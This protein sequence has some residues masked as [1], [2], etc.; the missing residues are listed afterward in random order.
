M[1]TLDLWKRIGELPGGKKDPFTDPYGPTSNC[2]SSNDIARM[3]HLGATLRDREHLKAC[4]ECRD[5]ILRFA[6]ATKQ[7]VPAKPKAGLHKPYRVVCAPK[8]LV[9]SPAVCTVNNLGIVQAI[10]MEIL[11]NVSSN[12]QGL[13]LTLRGPV[14]G[15]ARPSW[16]GKCF[17]IKNVRASSEVVKVLQDHNRFMQ[18]V[19]LQFG[20]TSDAPQ[21][22]A[23][24]SLEFSKEA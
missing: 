5:R 15:S 6:E 13:T 14:I 4:S 16:E 17:H 10:D 18:P 2:F 22:I 24:C 21:L 20:E 3:F 23:N 19:E 7:P 12:L 8:A 11:T 9:Y 1:G